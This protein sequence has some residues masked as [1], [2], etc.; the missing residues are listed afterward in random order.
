MSNRMVKKKRG[1]PPMAC[2]YEGPTPETVAKLA[3]DPL[4]AILRL[5]GGG[6]VALEHAAGEIRAVFLAVCGR[7]MAGVGNLGGGGEMPNFIAWAHAGTYLPWTRMTPRATL[8]AVI[9]VLIDRRTVHPDL[10][11]RVA[12]ALDGYARRM[13]SRGA[14]KPGDEE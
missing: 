9:D 10:A 1:R 4:L 6:D 14:Y 13:K 11:V 3:P 5:H 8:E 2:A 12:L 7:L